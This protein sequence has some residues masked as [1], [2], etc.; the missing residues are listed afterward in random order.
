M[1]KNDQNI[2][3]KSLIYINKNYANKVFYIIYFILSY[4]YYFY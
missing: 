1:I 2:E 3:K 4:M